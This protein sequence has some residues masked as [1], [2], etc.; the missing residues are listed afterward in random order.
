[1]K[2]RCSSHGRPESAP[3]Y[4]A[5]DLARAQAHLCT[6][7][8]L[9]EEQWKRIA[10]L[11]SAGHDTKSSQVLLQTMVRLLDAMTCY[12][13]VVGGDQS[14]GSRHFNARRAQAPA[15]DAADL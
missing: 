3:V 10:Q 11:A 15:A 6:A 7:T 4:T 12:R 14:N 8:H 2:L 13:Q 5:A 9:V 1:M